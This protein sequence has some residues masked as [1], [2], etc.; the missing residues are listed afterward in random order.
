M[1]SPPFDIETAHRDACMLAWINSSIA[2]AIYVV[3]KA[4]RQLLESKTIQLL[5]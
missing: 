1:D 2:I 5:G 4:I 3:A